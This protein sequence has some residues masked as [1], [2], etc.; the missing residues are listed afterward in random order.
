[1]KNLNHAHMC[2][3]LWTF[4]GPGWGAGLTPNIVGHMWNSIGWAFLWKHLLFQVHSFPSEMTSQCLE[5]PALRVLWIRVVK[6][7]ISWRLLSYSLYLSSDLHHFL[8]GLVKWP[9]ACSLY[10]SLLLSDSYG[11]H[12]RILIFPKFS[13]SIVNY[14]HLNIR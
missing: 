8:P 14:L 3:L 10:S 1:M 5:K 9:H 4:V 11:N 7:C 13:Y 6:W 2:H 12:H